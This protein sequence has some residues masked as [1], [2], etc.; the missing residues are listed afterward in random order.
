MQKV[1]TCRAM[2]MNVNRKLYEGLVVYTA[3]YG[4]ETWSMTVAE[5]KILTVM[6]VRCL[7]YVW[8]NPYGLSKN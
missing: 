1:F 3:C 6:E 8:S 7:K 2:V 5:K 4:A